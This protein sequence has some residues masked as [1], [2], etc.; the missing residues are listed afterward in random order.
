MLIKRRDA[1]GRVYLP[2]INP[3]VRPA[4]DARGTLTFSNAA[5]D[6]GVAAAPAQY[7][8]RWFSFD[9]ATGETAAIGE[10]T[11]SVPRLASPAGLP[12]T[13]G[14]FVQVDIT[15]EGGPRPGGGQC[16]CGSSGLRMDGDRWG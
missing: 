6:A 3:V 15:A 4:L 13:P 14:A 1:I 12:D 11:A 16:T 2:K 8:A 10:T 5:V 9:N 7:R